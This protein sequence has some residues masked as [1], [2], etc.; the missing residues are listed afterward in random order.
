MPDMRIHGAV[1]K[2]HPRSGEVEMDSRKQRRILVLNLVLASLILSAG[3]FVWEAVGAAQNDYTSMSDAIDLMTEVYQK[4]LNEYIEEIP[5]SDLAR[6]AV[7]GILGELDP[8][9]S[10]LPPINR[11]QLMEDSKGEFGGLGIEIQ[12]MGDY[13]RIMSYPLPDTPAERA[14]LQSGDEIVEIDG[15]ST[16]GISINEV[17][18]KLR[19]KVGEKVT[20][21][22]KRKSRDDLLKFDIVRAK[23][24]LHNV[25][26][27]GEIDDGIGYIQLL[28]FNREASVEIEEAID[29]LKKI[30]GLKGI[31]LDLRGNPGGLLRASQ[32]VGDAFLPKGAEIVSVKGRDPRKGQSLFAEKAPYLHPDVPLVVLIN[33]AS[34]SAS[35]I[36]AGAIQDHDRGVL[37]GDTSFGK[38]SVQTVFDRLP[39]ASGIK[40]T[41]AHYY[42]PSKRC[43]HNERNFDEDYMRS[44]IFGDED[45]EASADSVDIGDKYYTI[46]L[47][48]IVYGGGG[49]KPDIIIKE[50][51]FGNMM[52]QLASMGTFSTF[53]ADFVQNNPDLTYDLVITDKIVADFKAFV[54]DEDVFTYSIPGKTR[55]EEF[56]K[57]I[58]RENYNGDILD[59]VDKLE[60]TLMSKRDDDFNA[61][62]ENIKRYLRREILV[63]KFGSRERIRATKK[64]DI[65]LLKAIEVLNDSDRYNAILSPGAETGVKEATAK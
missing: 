45:G 20:I 1:T 38:G 63:S 24:P 51:L 13:P 18:S 42:T 61:S 3:I 12:V 60:E 19:G 10:Y 22:V 36:V 26:Y 37:I 64:W 54:A 14:R 40:L 6:D 29:E 25:Q 30:E 33:R 43:I 4:V 8:Y 47:E 31:I 41:T 11:T 39:G 9:S 55:L 48:R 57:I 17:V 46:N 28:R 35:E 56:R 15:E 7:E 62:L 2:C 50:K 49:I 21:M 65:Q 53:A 5:P 34:A 58:K 16:K 44:Q 32:E 27:A 52:V 23:I 59:E